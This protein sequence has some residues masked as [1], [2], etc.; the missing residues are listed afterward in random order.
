MGYFRTESL[1]IREKESKNATGTSP[2]ERRLKKSLAAPRRVARLSHITYLHLGPL[3]SQHSDIWLNGSTNLTLN[4]YPQSDLYFKMSPRLVIHSSIHPSK[5][6]D[7]LCARKL[8][9]QW[10]KLEWWWNKGLPRWCSDKNSACQCRRH[11]RCRFKP[12][13]GKIPWS[14][15]RKSTPV[16][17]P[18]KFHGQ[19]SLAGYSPWVRRE[20][21]MTE[22]LSTLNE[23]GMHSPSWN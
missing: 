21:D 15:K 22:W 20:S 16:F 23:T 4:L 14:W 2:V 8:R 17:L 5:N 7:F 3:L 18:G 13:V 11:K 9:L 12:L 10:M 6:D 19:R 1:P